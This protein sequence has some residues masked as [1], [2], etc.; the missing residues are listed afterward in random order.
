MT[1]QIINS[2]YFVAPTSEKALEHIKKV[3]EKLD[4]GLITKNEYEKKINELK[5]YFKD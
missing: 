1:S 4:L 2:K 5:K 3:K